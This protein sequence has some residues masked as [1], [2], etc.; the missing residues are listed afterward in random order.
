M[1][2]PIEPL[3]NGVVYNVY[4]SKTFEGRPLSSFQAH[5]IFLSHPATGHD[6]G[7]S[8]IYNYWSWARL[9]K[10]GA[11]NR[12]LKLSNDGPKSDGDLWKLVHILPQSSGEFPP[13][14]DPEL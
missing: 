10:H 1:A 12:S 7:Y 13:E 11:G 2:T 9:S 4:W 5:W 8:Y 3:E 14:G 6:D